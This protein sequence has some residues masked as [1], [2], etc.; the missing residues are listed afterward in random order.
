MQTEQNT[1]SVRTEKW[2]RGRTSGAEHHNGHISW[3]ENYRWHDNYTDWIN[4]WLLFAKDQISVFEDG[5]VKLDI[6]LATM[7][8]GHRSFTYV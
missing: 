6:K 5:R 3:Q 1:V 2:T 7:S 4:S 8:W